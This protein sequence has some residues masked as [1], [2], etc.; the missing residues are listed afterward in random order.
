MVMA[1]T[2][3]ENQAFL[4]SLSETVRGA[5][6]TFWLATRFLPSDQR[7]RALCLLCLDAE[8]Y[9]VATTTQENMIALIR[10]QWWRDEIDKLEAGQEPQQT[11]AALALAFLLQACSHERNNIL[12]LIDT[13]DDM[14]STG[15]VG[16]SETL[17]AVLF[18]STDHHSGLARLC[19]DVFRQANQGAVQKESVVSLSEAIHT[20][21][22][23]L[24]PW[25]CLFDFVPE[26][27]TKENLS[28]FR[29]R[30]RIWKAFLAGEKR[31]AKKLRTLAETA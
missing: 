27:L 9:R 28:P 13:Y 17:F 24:W 19:G 4:K 3:R 26:W 21:H 8:F 10:L 22:A 29:K 30:W 6:E 31:L 14:L 12:R 1:K 20:A 15:S 11:E 2:K 5:H 23:D 7:K 18:S 25:L 16:H